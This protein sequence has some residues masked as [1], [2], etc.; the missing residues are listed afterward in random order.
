MGNR[1][2]AVKSLADQN[3]NT[4]HRYHRTQGVAYSSSRALHNQ[5][6]LQR[7]RM[8]IN[9]GD[10]ALPH[11]NFTLFREIFK[12]NLDQ[13]CNRLDFRTFGQFHFNLRSHFGNGFRNSFF[14]DSGCK[15]EWVNNTGNNN[16]FSTISALF[17]H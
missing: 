4:S 10:S 1:S 17:N 11:H 3:T 6:V 9:P 14:K 16:L 2:M 5:K 15:R 7:K 8:K 13:G 12:G